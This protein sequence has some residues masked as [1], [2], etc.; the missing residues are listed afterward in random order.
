MNS[1]GIKDEWI[2]V[3]EQIGEE[4]DTRS[5]YSNKALTAVR[6]I[7]RSSISILMIGHG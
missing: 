6:G 7:D 3:Y 4:S 2:E 5:V 1:D